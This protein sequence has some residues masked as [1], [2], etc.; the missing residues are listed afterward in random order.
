MLEANIG[1]GEGCS[2]AT[3]NFLLIRYKVVLLGNISM[4]L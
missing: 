4:C 1:Y 3:L 2:S